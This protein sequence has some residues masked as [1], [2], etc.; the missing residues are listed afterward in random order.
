MKFGKSVRL[1]LIEGVAD[2]RWMCELSN[3]TGKAY[4]I[5]RTFLRQSTDRPDINYTGIY[6]LLGKNDCSDNVVYIGEAEN[7]YSRLLQHL[8]S[9][10]E[11]EEYWT[12]CVVFVSKDNNLNKAH[13]KYL[14]NRMYVLV[15]DADRYE[16][17]NGNIPA[18]SSLSEADTA[19]M[20]E[21]IENAKLLMSAMGHKL[22]E[23]ISGSKQTQVSIPKFHFELNNGEVSANGYPTSEGFVVL[24]GSKITPNN[25]SSVTRGVINKKK[26]LY[27]E[28]VVDENNVFTR[29]W[30]FS[31]ASAAAVVVAGYSINGKIAWKTEKG[32]TLKEFEL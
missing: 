12:E 16:I 25:A 28:G 32:K 10:D 6:F 29:D 13:V 9:D 4:K 24:K 2:G 30:L 8:N 1:F 27:S 23:P 17:I 18:K 19:E 14:E 15:K 5:P 20:E 3:W 11:K 22:L 7:V 21:F 26:E 31:S